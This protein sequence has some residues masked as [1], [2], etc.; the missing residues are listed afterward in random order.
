M[1]NSE[2]IIQDGVLISYLGKDTEVIIP[3]G[4]TSIGDSVFKGMFNITKITIPNTVK[5]IG[6]FAFKGCK[7]LCDI[8]F[9]SGL[10]KLDDYAFHRCHSLKKVIL[11]DTLTQIGRCVFHYCDSLEMISIKGVKKF[12][13]QTFANDTNLKELHINKDLDT[14]NITDDILTGCIK[15]SKIVLSNGDEYVIENLIDAM[16]SNNN[17]PKIIKDIARGVYKTMSIQDGIL[18][19]FHVNLKSFELPEGITC[20]EKSCF[21]DRKGIVSITLPKSLKTIRN[22]AFKNCINLEEIHIL[23]DNLNIDVDAFKGCNNLNRIVLSSGE[24]F[25]INSYLDSNNTPKIVKKIQEQVQSDFYISGN[26]LVSYRGNEERVTVPNGITIIGEGCFAYNE[27]IGKVILPNTVTDIQEDAFKGCVSMQT[28]SLSE[29]LI[30]IERSAFENCFKLLRIDLPKNVSKLGQSA[31]KRCFKLKTFN[32]NDNLKI[33]EDMVFYGC[34]SL[35]DF[36][37]PQ[38]V[39]IYGDL[40]FFKSSIKYDNNQN[41]PISIEEKHF[42]N[43]IE[44][45]QYANTN[46]LQSIT[47]YEPCTI[48]KYAFSNCKYLT[49][50]RLDNP[51]IVVEDNAFEKCPNLRSVYLNVK[52]LGNSVLSFCK[53]LENVTILG[54]DRL[55]N[56]TFFGCE[57]LKMLEIPEIKTIGERC[58]EECTSLESF[59]FRNIQAIEERAFSRCENLRMV[60]IYQGVVGYHAFE[61]CTNLKDI[62]I[63]SDVVLKSGAFFGS[64]NIKNI[65]LDGLNYSVSKYSQS[66]NCLENTLPYRIQEILS[67]IYLC[68][69]VNE[70]LEITE[71]NGNAKSVT[72]PL[73][74]VSIGDETFRDCLRLQDIN[75]P[76]SV[77]YIGKMAFIGTSWLNNLRSSRSVVIINNML[78]DA[79]TC[80]SY[81]EIPKDVIRVCGWAFANNYSLS[82]V[83]ISSNRTIIDE[84]AFRNCINLKTVTL[85]DGSKYNLNG[86]SDRDNQNLPTTVRNIFKDCINCFKTQGDTLIESTGNIPNLV[87]ANGIKSIG[88]SVYKDCNLLESIKFSKDTISIGNNAFENSKWLKSVEDAYNV[89]NIGNFAFSGC[90]NL[91]KIELSNHLK[92]IG[93]RA[94]EHCCNLKEIIIPEGITEIQEKTFFRCKSLKRIVLPSTLKVIHKEAFAFCS[95]LEEIIFPKGLETIENRAFAWCESLK[96]YD[97]SK[98]T[99]LGEHVFFNGVEKS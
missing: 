11:P 51:N 22:Q 99:I 77:K 10:I 30:N 81:F 39:E 35:K 49:D 90:Q 40:V 32:F 43:D 72:I 73:D 24:T 1:T 6:K 79:T 78:V 80:N 34:Q 82:E 62:S 74:I 3:N 59:N 13:M 68:F 65:K 54:I 89:E 63:N 21:Y 7:K 64:T 8:N 2:F 52:S 36:N 48:G 28:I 96:N 41:K 26:I 42:T 91:E 20:I 33:I 25:N 88:D 14:S 57:N 85:E 29:S 46:D 86:I 16:S 37:L 61:D 87:L 45:Y 5:T 83:K 93:K 27:A 55:P 60:E 70:R 56:G 12:Q 47:I 50:I 84:F 4:V 66:I 76:S 67:S 94:F 18:Y 19:K 92:T 98:N 31:F 17:I 95:G 38:G 15:I 53:N 69:T 44:P 97:I 9:P 71:Y 58:F 23:N 75:I